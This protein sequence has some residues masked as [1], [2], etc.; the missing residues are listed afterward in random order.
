[1]QFSFTLDPGVEGAAALWYHFYIHGITVKDEMIITINGETVA[2]VIR[3]GQLILSRPISTRYK[4]N[5][6]ILDKIA[7]NDLPSSM[8][9]A[10]GVLRKAGEECRLDCCEICG[11][12]GPIHVMAEVTLTLC[13]GCRAKIH[14]KPE[15]DGD[16]LHF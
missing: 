5:I 9:A 7:L 2:S 13:N 4:G 15:V 16:D 8:V 12:P 14:P 3:D 10:F 11:S 1:M 6:R